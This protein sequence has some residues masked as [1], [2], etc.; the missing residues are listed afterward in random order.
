[1][2]VEKGLI[3]LQML[4]YVRDLNSSYAIL[5]PCPCPSNGI[6]GPKQLTAHTVDGGEAGP[7]MEEVDAKRFFQHSISMGTWLARDTTAFRHKSG[8]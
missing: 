5:T 2:A 8:P 1:M 7:G 3:V 4:Y 6:D